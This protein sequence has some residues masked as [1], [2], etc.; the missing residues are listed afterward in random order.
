MLSELKDDMSGGK[1]TVPIARVGISVPSSMVA[2]FDEI[3]ETEGYSSRSEGIREAI[4]E[5]NQLYDWICE[6]NG[7]RIAVI[8]LVYDPDQRGL[9][10]RINRVQSKFRCI[11]KSS[12]QWKLENGDFLRIISL[13]GDAE[14][15]RKVD[16][17]M[18]ALKGVKCV[19]LTTIR[20]PDTD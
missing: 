3:L 9:V 14:F 2:V 20:P 5:Y 13:R 12:F 1:T 17:R 8:S 19:K 10:D 16:E 4:R 18:M 11:I 7:D 6:V 15:L